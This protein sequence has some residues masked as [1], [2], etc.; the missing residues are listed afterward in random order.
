MVPPT[1]FGIVHRPRATSRRKERQEAMMNWF[2]VNRRRAAWIF[3]VVV[4]ALGGE[5][6]NACP[7]IREL[8]Q[9]P[10]GYS[11]DRVVAAARGDVAAMLETG[12]ALREGV[13]VQRDLAAAYTW[14]NLAA[15]RSSEAARLRS[16]LA[17]CLSQAELL[18]AQQDSITFLTGIGEPGRARPPGGNP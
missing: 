11:N 1:P 2:R 16:E 9:A 12:L 4:A 14:F 17:R 15:E 10:P 5:T 3:V 13:G 7:S 6:A 18:K 8:V